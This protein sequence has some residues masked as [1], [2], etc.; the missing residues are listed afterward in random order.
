MKRVTFERRPQR[1]VALLYRYFGEE[2]SRQKE[3]SKGREV[4][5]CL[6]CPSNSQE[7]RV[8]GMG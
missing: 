3:Q 4:V 2:H 6:E 7:A 8:P 1:G 5:M